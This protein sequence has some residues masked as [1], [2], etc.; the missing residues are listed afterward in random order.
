[1]LASGVQQSDSVI[2]IYTYDDIN[3]NMAKFY[4]NLGQDKSNNLV[5]EMTTFSF[6]HIGQV[7]TVPK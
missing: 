5:L 3:F 6:H 7:Q 1:M 2:H 4:L